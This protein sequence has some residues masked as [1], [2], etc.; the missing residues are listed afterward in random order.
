MKTLSNAADFWNWDENPVFNGKFI[1]PV[2]RETD[3]EETGQKAGTVMGYLFEDA[4]GETHIIGASYQIE[5]A[6]TSKTVG[7]NDALRITFVNTKKLDGG[8]SVRR[9][10]IEL[11]ENGEWEEYVKSLQKTEKTKK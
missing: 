5:K 11:F 8:R 1:E 4:Q 2:L 9:F 7:V 3:D 6:L 10:K